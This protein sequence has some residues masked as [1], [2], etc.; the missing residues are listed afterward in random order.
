VRLAGGR[1]IYRPASGS[2]SQYAKF[3]K[4]K[5]V[6]YQEKRPSIYEKTLDFAKEGLFGDQT[7]RA[8][9]T[10]DRIIYAKTKDYEFEREYRLAIP[11]GEEEED[12]RTLPYHPDEVTEVYLGASMTAADRADLIARGG[13][14][15][16]P[17]ISVFQAKR[18]AKRGNSGDIS[19]EAI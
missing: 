11:L 10:L 14:A 13:K 16:N 6:T 2:R 18:V 17:K 4:F 19:F 3:Q 7:A 15:V 8:R 9:S 1:Q 12:Y 5:P